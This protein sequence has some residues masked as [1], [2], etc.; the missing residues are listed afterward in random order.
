ML[1]RPV[2][3]FRM[4]RFDSSV[5]GSHMKV[6]KY[7]G[8][9]KKILDVGCASGYLA[10]Q[11]KKN[12]CYVVGVELDK[13][14]ATIAKHYCDDILVADA[15]QI[16]RLIRNS[17]VY[18]VIV[19]ADVLEH[20]RR[21]DLVLLEFKRLLSAHGYIVASVPNIAN[22]RIRLKL[23]LGSFNYQDGGILDRT[24]LRFFTLKTLRRL[25][26]STGYDI[27]EIDTTGLSS[28]L[29]AFPSMFAT[30]F[31]VIARPRR[32]LRN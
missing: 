18:D 7:V 4:Y 32:K 14:I 22:W 8:N 24:H 9:N 26:D 29:R 10:E 3:N 19:F 1:F 15:E 21:P 2:G 5:H 12:G 31:I 20:L 6:I 25:F 23:L 17:G 28:R 30:Q 11:F 27:L 13:E 16:P